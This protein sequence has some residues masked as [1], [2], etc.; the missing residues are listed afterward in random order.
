MGEKKLRILIVIMFMTAAIASSG[1]RS[2]GVGLNAAMPGSGATPPQSALL[3]LFSQSPTAST[4]V[5]EPEGFAE[6]GNE[7]ELSGG[8]AIPIDIDTPATRTTQDPNL[9]TIGLDT[10]PGAVSDERL[11]VREDYLLAGGATPSG[12]KPGGRHLSE[13][14]RN[15]PVAAD[16]L[17][18]WGHRRSQAITEGLSLTPPLSGSDTF[19]LQTPRA[20]AEKRDKTPIAPNL[21]VGD[22]V[23][24]LGTRRGVTY[25]RWAG[26][27]A[28]TLSIDFDLSGA[29]PLITDDPAYRA[30]LERAGKAWSHRIVDT[31][32][33][34]ERSPGDLKGWLTRIDSSDTAP[35][36]RVR[37]GPK[38][39]I[40]TG[41]EINVRDVGV[42]LPEGRVGRGNQ[43]VQ[44][45][46][47]SWEPHF[48]SISLKREFLEEA[49][50]ARLL[51]LIVHEIGHV[52]G[53]WT[54][55]SYPEHL[56]SYIDKTRGAWSG[57]NLVALHGD[58]APVP[59]RFRSE[60]L[61][62]W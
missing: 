56:S 6:Y 22:E 53:A 32:T 33:P 42:F 18:H 59:R 23:R 26:G 15:N 24:I 3:P 45:R 1:C 37:V 12:T 38:G 31:W 51:G 48:G 7:P 43:G 19:D 17:D 46:G 39:E 13:P 9:P 58:P 49:S 55:R 25:G 2:S 57:L 27:P 30:L 62:R 50:G 5:A 44:P 52:L 11:A 16:L 8:S 41:L 4:T 34:W 61:G 60:S 28:D 40:S 36:T 21:Q 47:D 14:A 54:T 35:R 20:A 10:S 29:S